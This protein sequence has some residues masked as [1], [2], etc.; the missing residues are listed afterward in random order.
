MCSFN[1]F[2]MRKYC[3]VRYRLRNENLVGAVFSLS[4]FLRNNLFRWSPLV[5]GDEVDNGRI[6]GGSSRLID[7]LLRLESR[8][9]IYSLKINDY[10]ALRL[11]K[12][13]PNEYSTFLIF[14]LNHVFLRNSI[15]ILQ[16][17]IRKK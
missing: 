15:S 16:A 1:F 14:M 10:Q 6:E 13:N 2:P 3:R 12:L 17:L 9:A 7:V 5:S 11:W 8:N 4:I